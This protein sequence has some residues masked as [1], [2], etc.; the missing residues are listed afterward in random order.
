MSIN[1]AIVTEDGIK[2]Y[3]FCKA[4]IGSFSR[5]ELREYFQQANIFVN[6]N[7]IR[8]GHD[9]ETMR[10]SIGDE[11][12]LKASFV[13][14]TGAMK[15]DTVFSSS[16]FCVFNKPTGCSVTE[17]KEYELAIRFQLWNGEHEGPSNLLYRLEKSISGLSIAVNTHSDFT[18]LRKS[19]VSSDAMQPELRLTYQAL[20]C[21]WLGDVGR[22]VTIDTEY[23]DCP[24][25]TLTVVKTCRC[26]ASTHL[27]LVNITPIFTPNDMGLGSLDEYQLFESDCRQG[28][29]KSEWNT[30]AFLQTLQN[31]LTNGDY[32]VLNH[33]TRML[34]AVR[35]ALMR[36]GHG[37]VGDRDLV[38]KRKGL[39]AALVGVT[40]RGT[41]AVASDSSN[42][43]V[44]S[45]QAHASSQASARTT[46][47][48][49]PSG[50]TITTTPGMV[51]IELPTSHKFLKLMEREEKMWTA[52]RDRDQQVLAAYHSRVT[53][54]PTSLT[55][56]DNWKLCE[57]EMSDNDDCDS[58]EI[59]ADSESDSDIVSKK[60]IK[61]SSNKKAASEPANVRLSNTNTDS[62]V[63]VEYITGEAQFCGLWFH[64]SPAVM[65]PRRSS[66]ALVREAVR[67]CEERWN[68]R[69]P[70]STSNT[71]GAGDS[72]KAVRVLDLGTGSGCLLLSAIQAIQSMLA[73]DAVQS[74][75]PMAAQVTG[76][77]LDISI[78]ALKIASRNAESLGLASQVSLVEGSFETLLESLQQ[79][80]NHDD[81]RGDQGS[82]DV[83]L[84][85]P[86]YSSRK[87]RSR[88]SAAC[89]KYEPEIALFAP[90]HVRAESDGG[91]E[92]GTMGAYYM[93][94]RSLVAMHKHDS[95]VRS[96]AN[97][98]AP[99]VTGTQEEFSCV[100]V[101]LG[102]FLILEMGHGQESDVKRIVHTGDHGWRYVRSVRDHLDLVRCVVF[103]YFG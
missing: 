31:P 86:P 13:C 42:S 48:D 67:C 34:K 17:G 24:S 102:A 57:E 46:S 8:K 4:S 91:S 44:G 56:D 53:G 76:V 1:T 6:G 2:L 90:K 55:D 100:N 14:H 62:D 83:I 85:N 41:L 71:S 74:D 89:R 32:K 29:D 73:G 96:N 60:A 20:I 10:L 19:M 87:E 52:A 84:C 101:S 63:P 9:D 82:F 18:R 26:R 27:S 72:A 97:T 28:I 12:C 23:P 47:V 25:L 94:S 58:P 78:D 65:I 99:T 80:R 66:E 70:S 30:T 7:R 45:F 88:L 75:G 49:S 11:V 40:L 79:H 103:Q 22:C 3:N 5:R 95:A 35:C 61:Q 50:A 64:V 69:S 43:N 16:G 37:I 54:M 33:P 68:R 98:L 77:G 59:H 93:L 81:G 92:E 15:L 39:Y 21:G 36:A 51:R 38:K